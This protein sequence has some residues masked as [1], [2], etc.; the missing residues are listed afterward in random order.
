MRS[1]LP[2]IL[3]PATLRRS[4]ISGLVLSLGPTALIRAV[5]DNTS[6]EAHSV[7][8]FAASQRARHNE[9]PNRVHSRYGL[10]VLLPLLPTSSFDDAVTFGYKVQTQL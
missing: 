9:R 7:L 5:P 4:E 3:S 1:N 8:G 2:T 6:R 10:V